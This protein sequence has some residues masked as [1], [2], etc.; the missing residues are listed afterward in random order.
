MKE[1]TKTLIISLIT[2]IGGFA[3][4]IIIGVLANSV[5][6]GIVGTI[7]TVIILF[8]IELT[9][10]DYWFKGSLCSMYFLNFNGKVIYK[11]MPLFENTE[12]G[13]ELLRI[14]EV[15]NS[16]SSYYAI[17]FKRIRGGAEAIPRDGTP[18]K[19]V[20]GVDDKDIVV[21]KIPNVSDENKFVPVKKGIP[22]D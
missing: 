14:G 18:F 11:V 20:R 7:I 4:G 5:E 10:G 2:F 22:A 1:N 9:I 21:I 3:N 16:L 19:L 17:D 15:D 12:K 8:F 6:M 13:F